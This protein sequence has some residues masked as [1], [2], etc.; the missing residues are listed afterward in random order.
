MSKAP[1]KPRACHHDWRKGRSNDGQV[2]IRRCNKCDAREW[3][4]VKPGHP[5]NEDSPWNKGDPR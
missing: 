5:L 4:A 1:R 2:A 3:K